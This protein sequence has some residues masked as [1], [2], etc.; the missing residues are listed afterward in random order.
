M[1]HPSFLQGDWKLVETRPK[2]HLLEVFGQLIHCDFCTSWAPCRD[3][4]L[5]ST[6][7]TFKVKLLLPKYAARLQSNYG[8]EV[9]FIKDL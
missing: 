4:I 1:K 2:Y 7:A 9:L 6:L 3:A 5:K 8:P